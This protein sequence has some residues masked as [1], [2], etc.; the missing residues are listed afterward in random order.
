W[1]AEG[2]TYAGHAGGY[3]EKS[4]RDRIVVFED[5]DGDGRHDKRTVFAD[6]LARLTSIEVGFGGVWALTLPNLVFIPDRNRDD[7]PDGPPE[8]VLDGFDIANSAHTLANGLRWGPDGWLYGRQG[9]LGLS[10]L[11]VPGA[12]DS[13]R[14]RLNPGIWRVHPQ[15]HTVEVVCEGTTNPWGMDWNEYGEAFFINTVIGH[16]WHVIPGA[17]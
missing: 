9:I 3:Y 2:Y 16:L 7:V 13:A 17:H 10:A 11:G 6:G 15:R 8:V 1:V 14:V 12:P 5:T 4:L